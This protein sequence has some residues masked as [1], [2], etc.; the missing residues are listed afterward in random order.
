M[1]LKTCVSVFCKRQSEATTSIVAYCF[2]G[3][4]MTKGLTCRVLRSVGAAHDKNAPMV[5]RGLLIL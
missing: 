1:L 4:V 3:T 2:Q 5:G